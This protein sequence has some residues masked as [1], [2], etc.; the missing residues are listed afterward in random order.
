MQKYIKSQ[1]IANEAM[2]LR[3][4]HVD[5]ILIVEGPSDCTLFKKF[6]SASLFRIVIAFSK[7]D[8]LDAQ[9][10]LIERGDEKTICIVDSDFWRISVIPELKK[11]E[12]PDRTF[13]TDYHDIDNSMIKSDICF[14]SVM[15]EFSSAGKIAEQNKS[16][17]EIRDE[18]IKESR[19]IGKIRLYNELTNSGIKFESLKMSDIVINDSFKIDW[20]KLIKCLLDDTRKQN[21]TSSVIEAGIEKLPKDLDD[22]QLTCGQDTI[23]LI[24][25]SLRKVIGSCDHKETDERLLK[26][27]FR[28]AFP[29]EEFKSMKLMN[30]L[31]NYVGQHW[32]G[33]EFYSF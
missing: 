15:V 26:R 10:I 23:R 8:A 18:I 5:V 30:D 24:G 27:S 21:I 29:A 28:L 13:Y 14:R 7:D 17:L 33:R 16:F 22:W 25:L 9:K 2:M 4:A 12:L 31:I 32:P 3:K 20:A 6:L 1:V 19:N 11:I